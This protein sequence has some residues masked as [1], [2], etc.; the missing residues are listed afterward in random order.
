[1]IPFS[2]RDDNMFDLFDNFEKNFFGSSNSSMPAFRTDIRDLGDKFLM[3]AELPG[4]DKE[5]IQLDLKDGFL[6]IK[7]QHKEDQDEKDA[8]GSYI[9]RERRLGTFA[10]AFD[11]SGIDEAGITASYT[12]GI[13]SLTLPKQAPVV[14]AAR[15]IAIH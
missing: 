12:N 9:R 14:P 10:R 4:F 13:L 11:I 15:Q 6:T 1:M 3:E 7:A 5:D 2:R 8:Q